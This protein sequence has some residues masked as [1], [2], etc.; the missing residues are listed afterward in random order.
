LGLKVAEVG[1]GIDPIVVIPS[2]GEGEVFCLV[3]FSFD[4]VAIFVL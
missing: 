4:D 2:L 1:L 3:C